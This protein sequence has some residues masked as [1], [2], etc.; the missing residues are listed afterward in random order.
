MKAL[1]VK[2]QSLVEDFEKANGQIASKHREVDTVKNNYEKLLDIVIRKEK[3]LNLREAAIQ[4]IEN[5]KAV[6]KENDI[7]RAKNA[8]VAEKLRLDIQDF[9]RWASEERQRIA[10]R[11]LAAQEVEKNN[12]KIRDEVYALKENYKVQVLAE[13]AK[14]VK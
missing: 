10:N 14:K 3:E 9:K 5:L 12:A 8:E 7:A 2:L 13:I 11:D 1:L 4:P 6:I